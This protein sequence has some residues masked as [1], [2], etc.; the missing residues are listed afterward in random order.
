[1]TQESY[2]FTVEQLVEKTEHDRVENTTTQT[3]FQVTN[4]EPQVKRRLE[5][6]EVRLPLDGTSPPSTSLNSETIKLHHSTS[7]QHALKVES[8][9]KNHGP[10][11]PEV[12][13]FQVH[14]S[15]RLVFLF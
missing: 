6:V 11:L 14:R 10:R 5:P 9:L 15:A 3:H 1:M 2:G 12:S 7:F 4:S 8:K 13:S